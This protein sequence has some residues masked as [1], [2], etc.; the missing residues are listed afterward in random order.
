MKKCPY[1]AEEIQD[2]AIV[3]RFCGRELNPHNP[4]VLQTSMPQKKKSHT[5]LYTLLIAVFLLIILCVVGGLIG[6]PVLN[7]NN[8]KSTLTSEALA[9]EAK[10][11]CEQFIENRILTPST[12]K[13]SG[14]TTYTIQG[15]TDTFR[16][17]GD[18]D[19]Q[20]GFG[21]TIRNYFSCDVQRA[22]TESN[23][24]DRWHLL[25]LDLHP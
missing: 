16:L 15:Q 18:V 24:N 10:D 11:S 8:E 20:N 6:G 14:E 2:E 25:T 22:G 19:A 5:L 13:F 7:N 23:G 17:T 9:Y 4:V 1:C 3:C 21:A 12:A